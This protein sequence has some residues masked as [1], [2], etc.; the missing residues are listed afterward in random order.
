MSIY[1]FPTW[2]HKSLKD[3]SSPPPPL[4]SLKK[5]KL[6]KDLF[7]K[8]IH[9]L[10][11]NTIYLFSDDENSATENESENMEPVVQPLVQVRPSESEVGLKIPMDKFLS[12]FEKSN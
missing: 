7:L 5:L 12:S 11:N 10:I 1:F 4:S 2:F 8:F 9:F 3:V 6:G